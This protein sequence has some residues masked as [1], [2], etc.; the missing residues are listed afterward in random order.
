MRIFTFLFIAQI[1]W[2]FAVAQLSADS[3][4]ADNQRYRATL[5]AEFTNPEESPLTDEDL[6]DFR[7]LPFYPIVTNFC[8]IATFERVEAEPFEMTTTTERKPVYKVFGRATFILGSDTLVLHIYQN[9][10]LIEREEYRDY[11]FLPFTD[12]TNGEDTY[13]GGRYIDLRIPDGDTIII[14][15]NKA[16]N[17][18][19][20]YNY[21]Y[22]C[23]IPPKENAMDVRIEAG[24]KYH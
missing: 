20:A 16:Y 23:P 6:A 14:D 3:I 2:Q 17:P 22:S 4:I 15:F 18:Y 1:S 8:V 7:E 10:K 9:L 5:N 24:V 21:K 13:P 11:L 19:C 12:L